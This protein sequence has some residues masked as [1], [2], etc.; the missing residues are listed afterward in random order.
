MTGDHMESTYLVVFSCVGGVL[1]LVSVLSSGVLWARLSAVDDRQEAL[2]REV[3]KTAPPKQLEKALA[4]A[5]GADARIGSAVGELSKFKD[6][7]HAEM[8]RFYAIMRRNE[9]AAGFERQPTTTSTEAESAPPDEISVESLKKK[10]GAIPE[11]ESKSELRARARA[12]G[13]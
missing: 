3:L 2:A 5:E 11:Q 1:L 10:P 13:M 6:Q 8:Q 7:V 4:L 12:A 9:K